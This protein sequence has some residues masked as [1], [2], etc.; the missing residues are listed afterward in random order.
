MSIDPALAD[1][2]SEAHVSLFDARLSARGKDVG[3]ASKAESF[4]L[5]DATSVTA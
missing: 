5:P 4:K 1:R 3:S 2:S